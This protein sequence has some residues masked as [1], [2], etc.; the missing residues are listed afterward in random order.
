MIELHKISKRVWLW[1]ITHLGKLISR[2]FLRRPEYS[3]LFA[4]RYPT[5]K[6]FLVDSINQ[7]FYLLGITWV[8][9]F[10]SLIIEIT[11]CCNLKCRH[12]P[13][14]TKM[15]R[16][17]VM[18]DLELYKRIIDEN[19]QLDRLVLMNW[20]EPLLNP[21][22]IEMIAYA[23]KNN[24]ET[25]ITTNGTLL[26]EEMMYALLNSGLTR[27]SFS[28]DGVGETYRRIR[29]VDYE[30]L[31]ET[32][33]TF[34]RL[35]DELHKDMQVELSVTVFDETEKDVEKLLDRWSSRVHFIKLRPQEITREVARERSC[36]ELWRTAVFLSNGVI[37]GC[38][39]DYNGILSLGDTKDG[40]SR[41]VFNSKKMRQLRRNHLKGVFSL[42]CSMCD[43]YHTEYARPR[44][45]EPGVARN[46]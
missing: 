18:L 16:S 22:L 38:S 11:N 44:F 35:K 27:I 46:E 32:I 5:F 21:H 13:T 2:Y 20:G 30:V 1:T 19:P 6:S 31:E 10:R 14:H 25:H 41:A 17:R 8:I 15:D 42:P 29:G 36:R 24:I 12:C 43:E 23:H 40:S 33:L 34:C 39:V 4:T 26:T 45:N 9:P 7:T 37:T 28:M 3:Y